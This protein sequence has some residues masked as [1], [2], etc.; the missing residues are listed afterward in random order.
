MADGH[1]LEKIEN[2]PYLCKRST[3]RHKI[4]HVEA[5]RLSEQVHV[6][7]ISTFKIQDGGRRHLE[8]NKKR[9]CLCNGYNYGNV[10]AMCDRA[11]LPATRACCVVAQR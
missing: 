1:H 6:L 4:W 11:V 8:K 2:W 10:H 5:Y 9:L 7:K 3:D